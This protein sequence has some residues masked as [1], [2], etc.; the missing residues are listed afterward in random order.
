MRSFYKFREFYIPERMAGGIERYI[1]KGILPGD[2]LIAVL[3]N[4]LMNALGK[5]DSENIKN[6]PAYLTYLYNEA[7]A[8]CHGSPKAVKAWCKQGGLGVIV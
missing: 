8:N 3:E 6:L 7:P 5:A 2:F 4:D 1:N